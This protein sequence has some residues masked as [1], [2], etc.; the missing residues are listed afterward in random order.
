VLSLALPSLLLYGRS[1]LEIAEGQDVQQSLATEAAQCV[2]TLKRSIDGR[3]F[4]RDIFEW[5]ELFYV[6]HVVT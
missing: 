4:A 2:T 1:P 3:R 5:I 6:G